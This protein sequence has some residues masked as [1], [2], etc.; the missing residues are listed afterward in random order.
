MTI[1]RQTLRKRALASV[2]AT[3]SGP[4]P[5][6]S[7]IVIPSKGSWEDEERVRGDRGSVDIEMHRIAD[8]EHRSG[9]EQ[10]RP[11]P[12]SDQNLQKAESYRLH[13]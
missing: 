6:G 11:P 4:M 10:P 5:A 12:T 2:L 3:T 13:G 9:G 8:I 1:D 7:P